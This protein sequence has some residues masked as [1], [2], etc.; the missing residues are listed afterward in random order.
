MPVRSDIASWLDGI[1]QP[2]ARIFIALMNV[3]VLPLP[4][5]VFRLLRQGIQILKIKNFHA[6]HSLN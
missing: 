5:T 2:L 4:C 6:A 3:T 1:E